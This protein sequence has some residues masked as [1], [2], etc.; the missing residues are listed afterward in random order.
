MIRLCFVTGSGTIAR[1]GGFEP[2]RYEDLKLF[3]RRFPQHWI[4][5]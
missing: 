5:L 3:V 2:L 4:E 1:L